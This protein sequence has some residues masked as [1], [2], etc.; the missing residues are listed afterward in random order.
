MQMENKFSLGQ[1]Y[2]FIHLQA[3]LK[4]K[5][6]QLFTCIN[7]QMLKVCVFVM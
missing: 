5:K 2:L 3:N 7:Q 1:C 4:K 6:R